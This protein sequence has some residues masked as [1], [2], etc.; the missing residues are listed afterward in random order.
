MIKLKKTIRKFGKQAEKTGWEY[1]DI[2]RYEANLLNK[3]IK[4]I[5]RVRGKI[6]A[7]NIQGMSIYPMGEGDFILAIKQS[8]RKELKKEVGDEV[9]L[10]LEVD[11]DFAFVIPEDVMDGMDKED[12][13]YF[14]SLAK[15]HQKYFINYIESAKTPSTRQRRVVQCIRAFQ[16][17]IDYGSMIRRK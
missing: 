9:Y 12:Q 3:D 5:Y 6:D 15:S 11:N 17:R 14:Y 16:D 4:T 7:I 13:E 10:E 2:T 8:L 1:V